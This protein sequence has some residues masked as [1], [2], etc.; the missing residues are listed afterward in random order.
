[1]GRN[2]HK[3]T[4]AQLKK[5]RQN[6]PL[7]VPEE[8]FNAWNKFT[9]NGDVKKICELLN[10]SEPTAYRILRYGFVSPRNMSGLDKINSFFAERHKTEMEQSKELIELAKEK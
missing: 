3:I 7:T 5:A 10:I 2:R 1:M 8:T 4:P 6:Y 9:R